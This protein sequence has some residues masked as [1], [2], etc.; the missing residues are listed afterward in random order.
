MIETTYV[1]IPVDEIIDIMVDTSLNNNDSIR[2]SIDGSL[3]I[4]KFTTKFPGVM[5]GYKK[6][7]HIEILNELIKPEWNEGL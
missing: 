4:L 3:A 2:Y 6:Y 7:T 1:I 5:Q